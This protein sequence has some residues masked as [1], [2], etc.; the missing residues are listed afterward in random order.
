MKVKKVDHIG[1]II[2]IIFILTLNMTKVIHIGSTPFNIALS[3]FILPLLGVLLILRVKTEKFKN[4]FFIWQWAVLLILWLM[5]TGIHAILM[6]EIVAGSM[7][8]LLGEVTKTI[9]SVAY[10]YVGFNTLKIIEKSIFRKV[11]FVNSVLFVAIGIAFAL[12]AQMP[13]LAPLV[14][15]RYRSFFMGTYTDPN[16]AATFLGLNTFLFFGFST[17][18]KKKLLRN[19]YLFMGII[20]SFLILLTDSRGGLIAIVLAYICFGV[21]HFRKLYGYGKELLLAIWGMILVAFTLDH[22]ISQNTFIS[23]LYYSFVNF[24]SG[25]G[26]REALCKTAWQMALDHPLLGV[27]RGNYRLNSLPYFEKLNFKYID[28]IPHNTYVGLFAETGILGLILFFIPIGVILVYSVRTFKK[29]QNKSS[30]HLWGSIFCSILII[31]GVQG[32]ILNVEN[33]RVLWFLMG[34]ILYVVLYGCYDQQELFVKNRLEIKRNSNKKIVL[35]AM[36]LIVATYLSRNS[37][38]INLNTEWIEDSFIYELP[39]KDF[40]KNTEFE[41]NYQIIIAQNGFDQHGV[42]MQ[43]Q[44]RLITG[45]IVILDRILYTPVNGNEKII[46]K[47]TTN[48]SDVVLIIKKINPQLNKFRVKPVSL[49]I[50][51]EVVALDQ[52]NLLLKKELLN[53]PFKFLVMNKKMKA[54]TSIDELRDTNIDDFFNLSFINLESYETYDRVKYKIT[55]LK[56]LPYKTIFLCCGVP[57]DLS[58]LTRAEMSSGVRYFKSETSSVFDTIHEHQVVYF[59]YDIPKDVQYELRFKIYCVKESKGIY[60]KNKFSDEIYVELGFN[61]INLQSLKHK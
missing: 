47:K 56:E 26:T 20:S 37:L 30:L 36:T 21:L 4:I 23:K 46:F 61:D 58:V 29:N 59:T 17:N 51:H 19:L 39:L 22:F 7:K 43:L 50:N 44:E 15:V 5:V 10:F 57:D 2:V 13:T 38:Y 42:E 33:Q 9:I 31:V 34:L 6:P 11:W 3:D 41:L 32:S 27:G 60:L 40:D 1:K 53:T 55:T 28:N 8:N 24:E 14:D 18:E 35:I 16:H 54:Y 49:K 12:M 52:N 25:L 48:Y 45:E